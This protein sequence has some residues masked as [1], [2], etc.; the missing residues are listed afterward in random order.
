M[1]KVSLNEVETVSN[2]GKVK[3]LEAEAN[4]K[5]KFGEYK[6]KKTE[7]SLCPSSTKRLQR[8]RHADAGAGH[9]HGHGNPTFWSNRRLCISLLLWMDEVSSFEI[10]VYICKSTRR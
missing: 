6:M 4:G 8:S 5:K 3:E 2:A 9:I 10:S 1:G 7:A